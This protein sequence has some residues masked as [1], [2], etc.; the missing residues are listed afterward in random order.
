[1]IGLWTDQASY[2]AEVGAGNS[3]AGAVTGLVYDDVA[4]WPSN[5]GM[6]S[7]YL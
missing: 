2:A 5:N 3:V 1:V 7:I 6:D 4:P